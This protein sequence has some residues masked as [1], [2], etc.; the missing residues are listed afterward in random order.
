M[1]EPTLVIIAA[2]VQAVLLAIIAAF[3]KVWQ[4]RHHAESIA[5]AK[6]VQEKIEVVHNDVNGKMAELLRVTGEAERAKG[7][8]EG[9]AAAKAEPHERSS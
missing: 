2:G 4:D 3:L 7:T 1:S 9:K 5:V 6:S 8:L